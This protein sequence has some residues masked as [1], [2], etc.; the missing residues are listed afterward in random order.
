MKRWNALILVAAT[1]LASA[2]AGRSSTRDDV[3]RPS[4]D[5]NVQTALDRIAASANQ[6]VCDPAHLKME[7]AEATRMIQQQAN[8]D[9]FVKSERLA[10]SFA[11]CGPKRNWGMATTAEFVGSQLAFAVLLQSRMPEQ[12]RNLDAIERDA[13]WADLLLQYA[14]RFPGERSAAEQDW[15]ILERGRQALQRASQ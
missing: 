13:R 15:Q 12:Q 11:F 7:I 6:P 4:D 8:Q 5:R 3:A 9:A 14:R 10:A 1:V 2:C